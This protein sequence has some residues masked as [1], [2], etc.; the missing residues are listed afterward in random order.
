MYCGYMGKVTMPKNNPMDA[1]RLKLLFSL[2]T[3][4]SLVAVI[5]LTSETLGSD[6]VAV[7][8]FMGGFL[9]AINGFVWDWGQGLNTRNQLSH[10]EWQDEEK[11]KRD[12]LDSVLQNMSNEQLIAL[13]S[14]L[15]DPGFEDDLQTMLGDD[16]EL[17]TRQR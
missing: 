14:R 6:V 13:R 1:I 3:W 2:I 9:V 8:L 16:G 12:M 11:R 10:K 5:V 15:E 7:L 4:G 17:I